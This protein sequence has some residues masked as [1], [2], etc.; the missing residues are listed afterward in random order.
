MGSYI[1]HMPH[2]HVHQSC[3]QMECVVI[4]GSSNS[5]I[6]G[7]FY[8]LQTKRSRVQYYNKRSIFVEKLSKQL[9][10][11]TG[12]TATDQ[13]T[14]PDDVGIA[15]DANQNHCALF[16]VINGEWKIINYTFCQLL[17]SE[18]K[19]D[20]DTVTKTDRLS[21]TT[22]ALVGA[23]LAGGVGAIVG[24][25]SAKSRTTTETKRITLRLVIDDLLH[26]VHDMVFFT[27]ENESAGQPEIETIKKSLALAERWHALLSIAIHRGYVTS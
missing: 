20:E 27:A 10:E 7:I 8:V 13:Y 4:P 22:G 3:E 24:G 11:L 21:Q 19:I 6:L 12:F 14:G 26:P 15:L 16:W 25:L 5:R 9:N 1:T 2:S 18:L 17:S 23:T